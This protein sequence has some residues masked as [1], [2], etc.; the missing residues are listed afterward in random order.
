MS[1]I[2]QVI[3]VLKFH[4]IFKRVLLNFIR[5]EVDAF[6]F[7]FVHFVVIKKEILI[8]T[9]HEHNKTTLVLN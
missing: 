4:Q 6:V 9:D 7:Y 8:V 1:G 5:T 3:Q 2:L